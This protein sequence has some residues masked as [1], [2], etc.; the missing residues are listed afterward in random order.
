V[1]QALSEA[2]VVLAEQEQVAELV[3]AGL[4]R[5][6]LQAALLVH[7]LLSAVAAVAD[8]FQIQLL[9]LVEELAEL[10]VAELE[11]QPRAIQD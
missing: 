7:Q 5:A 4:D 3:L 6:D 9:L 8:H 2:L 10:A 11:L 1:V